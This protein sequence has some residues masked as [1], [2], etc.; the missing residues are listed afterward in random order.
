[1]S[2]EKCEIG[3]LLAV[4][5]GVADAGVRSARVA[6]GEYA[7]QRYSGTGSGWVAVT[8]GYSDF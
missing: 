2:G 8:V 7:F 4:D 5:V 6:A 1:L 3:P